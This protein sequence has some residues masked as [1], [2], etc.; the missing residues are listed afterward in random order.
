MTSRLT[1]QDFLKFSGAALAAALG[2]GVRARGWSR[3]LRLDQK[4]ANVIII[5][6]DA[7]S[8]RHISLN[9]YPRSTTPNLDRFAE[10]AT[11]YHR[12]HAAANYTTPSTASLFTGTYPWK[13]RAFYGLP[14][15]SAMSENWFRL[16]GKGYHR[17]G[18]AQNMLADLILYQ[19]NDSLDSHPSLAEG[20]LT[21]S[22]FY[23]VINRIFDHD[24]LSATLATEGFLYSNK[25]KSGSLFFALAD[26]LS[27]QAHR[28]YYSQKYQDKY[29]GGLPYSWLNNMSFEQ[30]PV[31]DTA[32][33]IIEG[34]LQPSFIYLHFWSP[35][36]PYRPGQKFKG[37]FE[38]NP[39]RPI[40][41]PTSPFGS[42]ALDSKILYGLRTQYDEVVAQMD[43][44]FGRLVRYMEDKG[45]F[46]NSYV[47]VT[48]DHGQMFERGVEGH[49]TTLLYEEILHIPLIIRQPGQ[50]TRADIRSLTSNVDLFPT[51]LHLDD[52][53][54][55]AGCEGEIL[56]GLG[57]EAN[58]ERSVFAVEAKNNPARQPLSQ[59]TAAIFKRDYKL[60]HY[61]YPNY[62]NV[63][64]LYDLS[65]DPEEMNNLF[66]S[67]PVIAE[68][69]KAE[70]LNQIK[71]ADRPYL[72]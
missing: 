10:K 37:L 35:H 3:P 21:S 50:T 54:I 30:E 67:Q 42:A 58:V 71:Q 59:F 39:W 68:E 45:L 62:D 36:E 13:T 43:E 38:H 34:L 23:Q 26:K 55:P 19:C 15:D 60:I 1:R 53:P 28:K 64:E 66:A 5:L 49:T 24:G 14:L 69:L 7:L 8:A 6:F 2:V 47:I 61:R 31:F 72:T 44:E 25:N 70:L 48:S 63:S 17:V 33:K 51:L 27:V 56:P 40:D 20:S 22:P 65:S 16:L 46:E 11:I 32:M 18:Y 29:P 12:H 41:K 4:P 52:R 57:G 9:G